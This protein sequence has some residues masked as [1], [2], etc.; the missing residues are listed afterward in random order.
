MYGFTINPYAESLPEF[1][2]EKLTVLFLTTLAHV[3]VSTTV[4]AKAREASKKNARNTAGFAKS[5]V[6]TSQEQIY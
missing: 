2:I 5:P 1:A 4:P 6:K 3:P